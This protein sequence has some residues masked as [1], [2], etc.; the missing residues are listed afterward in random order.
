MVY[1]RYPR[2]RAVLSHHV[3]RYN[4]QLDMVERMEDW[5]EI[6]VI[7]PQRPMEVDRMCRDVEKLERLYEEGF[8]QG[9]LFCL[10]LRQ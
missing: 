3:E 7:R 2:L 1:G 6:V 10:S 9:E 4:E 8:E 5:G